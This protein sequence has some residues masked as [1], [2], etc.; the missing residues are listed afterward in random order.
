MPP[1][2]LYQCWL[3]IDPPNGCAGAPA[4]ASWVLPLSGGSALVTLLY[5]PL[6]APGAPKSPPRTQIL[7][8]SPTGQCTPWKPATG[9]PAPVMFYAASDDQLYGLDLTL[10]GKAYVCRL[11]GT[12]LATLAMD[13]R[14][15]S[16]IA[17]HS[18]Q[19]IGERLYWISKLGQPH[20]ARI[21]NGE[22]ADQRLEP[23][24]AP[25]NQEVHFPHTHICSDGCLYVVEHDPMP[26]ISKYHL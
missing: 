2:L 4:M 9:Y 6:V 3:E 12:H 19:W 26:R 10:P 23:T 5:H 20:S 11:D 24:P 8:T 1:Q 25:P 17:P 7:L 15:D 18:L 13:L 14:M 16:L 21:T 22:L